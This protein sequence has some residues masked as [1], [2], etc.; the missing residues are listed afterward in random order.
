MDYIELNKSLL[1][2]LNIVKKYIFILLILLL[3]F[4]VSHFSFLHFLFLL[5]VP[6]IANS[7]EVVICT[8]DNHMHNKH[9]NQ[10]KY[11]KNCNHERIRRRW[12]KNS[13]IRL[14]LLIL[15]LTITLDTKSSKKVL[16]IINNKSL[17]ESC[18]KYVSIIPNLQ[19]TV[20]DK[21]NLRLLHVNCK[22]P[23]NILRVAHARAHNTTTW[24]S[25]SNAW[26]DDSHMSG[27]TQ[28]YHSRFLDITKD[29]EDY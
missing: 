6:P 7:R 10:G 2:I 1:Y 24:P 13:M 9:K 21:N 5:L 29:E 14:K 16:S 19:F 18:N 4:S 15:L 20:P 11:Y 23:C 27:P 8:V 25:V 17:A 28:Y 12:S 26:V 22:L 3:H